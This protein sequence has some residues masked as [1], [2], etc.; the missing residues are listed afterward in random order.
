MM[1]F[2][3]TLIER[4]STPPRLM[5]ENE[6]P[7]RDDIQDIL[8]AA[9]SAPDHGAIRPWRFV[10]IEGENRAILGQTFANALK[11]RDREA[12]EEA[13]QKELNRPLRAPTVIAIL[14]RVVNDRPNVPPI[15]QIVATACAA[16]NMLVAA[17]AKGFGAILLTGKN[18]HDPNVRA[19][20]GLKSD[21]EIVSFLYLGKPNGEQPS[22]LRPDPNDFIEEFGTMQI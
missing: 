6:G 21:D 4:K 9:V 5:D 2:L 7:T 12:S 3:K 13:I 1:D 14:A 10:I 19:F 8:R 17:N 18:A 16:Q 20:F 15:E 22:K 11:T